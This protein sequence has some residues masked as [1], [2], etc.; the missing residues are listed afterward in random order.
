VTGASRRARDVVVL[1]LVVALAVLSACVIAAH[2]RPLAWDLALHAAALRHRTAAVTR[3]AIALT[4][5]EQVP[6]YTF[7][8]VGGLLCSRPRPGW[9]GAAVGAA[10]LGVGQ[11][12]R[13]TLS[14]AMGRPRPAAADWLVPAGGYAFPSG[15]TTTATMAAGLLGLGLT[16]LLRGRWRAVGLVLVACWAVAVG[17]TRLYLG[18]HWP[19]DVLAGWLLGS[20]LTMLAAA[21]LGVVGTPRDPQPL[22]APFAGTEA[23]P[24]LPAR[25]GEAGGRRV[26]PV[27]R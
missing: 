19:S 7:A 20:L 24:P 25:G 1:V 9:L 18:V 14:V 22:D 17:W 27:D 16:R 15:H 12:A 13:L 4:T 2:G 6:A 10:C 3:V 26:P 8:A 5:W 11:L 21:L 23:E